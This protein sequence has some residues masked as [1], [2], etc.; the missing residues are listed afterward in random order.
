MNINTRG[1]H[2]ASEHLMKSVTSE[3]LMHQVIVVVHL[4]LLE[5]LFIT[6]IGLQ[7]GFNAFL[8]NEMKT[9]SEVCQNQISK[10]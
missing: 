10:S 6:S 9:L 7:V 8:Y 2:S 3:F 1:A 4:L 5:H